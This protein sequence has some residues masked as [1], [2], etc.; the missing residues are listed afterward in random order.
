MGMLEAFK[1]EHERRLRNFMLCGV[2]L[3]KVFAGF[4]GDV[5]A[6]YENSLR[7]AVVIQI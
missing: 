5:V 6:R 4:E 2:T 7:K 1:P 3:Q